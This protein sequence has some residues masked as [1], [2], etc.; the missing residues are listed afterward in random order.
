MKPGAGLWCSSHPITHTRSHLPPTILQSSLWPQIIRSRTH[1]RQQQQ[2]VGAGVHMRCS[3]CVGL[4]PNLQNVM[5]GAR[6][7]LDQVGPSVHPWHALLLI[8]GLGRAHTCGTRFS[9]GT[10]LSSTQPD[11]KMHK[12]HQANSLLPGYA[13]NERHNL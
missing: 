5:P 8:W 6:L 13:R 9:Q 3:M 11:W 7:L 2:H 10:R 1:T 4:H 12:A